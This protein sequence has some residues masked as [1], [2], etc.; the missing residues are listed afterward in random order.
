MRLSML[1]LAA[2]LLT[3]GLGYVMPAAVANGQDAQI[4]AP[5]KAR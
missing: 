5:V 3:S 4:D 1:L 2:A